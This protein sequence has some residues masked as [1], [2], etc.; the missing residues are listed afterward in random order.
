MFITYIAPLAPPSS[1]TISGSNRVVYTNRLSLT[2]SASGTV[3]NYKWYLNNNE[4]ITST[5]SYIKS[6]A[7]LSDSG[8][9][10]CKAC[11]WA[12][13]TSSSSHTVNVIGWF[14]QIVYHVVNSMTEP[15]PVYQCV[16]CVRGMLGI[17]CCN[18]KHMHLHAYMEV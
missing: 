17:E 9:Y 15:L 4:L 1:V 18:M 16:L 14:I 13:C 7:Q 5:V 12:G 6:S 11:N 2:C 10:R 8:S 3:N